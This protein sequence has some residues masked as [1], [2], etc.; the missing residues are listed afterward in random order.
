[1]RLPPQLPPFW[2]PIG[3]IVMTPFFFIFTTR[4][5]TPLALERLVTTLIPAPLIRTRK[6][7]A[8]LPPCLRKTVSVVLRPTIS[9]PGVIR[10]T[11]TQGGG[12]ITSVI[13]T[14]AVAVLLARVV[15]GRLPDTKAVLVWVPDEL[16]VVTRVIVT[17]APAAIVPMSQFRIAPAVHVPCV[18]DAETN[19]FPAGI[20]SLTLTP[21]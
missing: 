6:P 18:E 15:S 14:V 17:V 8:A 16:G 4:L 19:V 3:V 21:V 11:A 2:P 7:A 5:M 20:G 12:R 13:W 9:W 1:M 10:L